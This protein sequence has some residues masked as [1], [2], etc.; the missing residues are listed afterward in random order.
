M[1]A[2]FVLKE[3]VRGVKRRRG[4]KRRCEASAGPSVGSHRICIY[5]PQL[6]PSYLSSC[7]PDIQM[8]V[9]GG[10]LQ[11][12]AVQSAQRQRRRMLMRRRRVMMPQPAAFPTLFSSTTRAWNTN[13]DR[14]VPLLLG[15]V[16]RL[17]LPAV[18]RQGR[19][20]PRVARRREARRRRRDRGRRLGLRPLEVPAQQLF[21]LD[22]LLALLVRLQR[23][24]RRT[25]PAGRVTEVVEEVVLLI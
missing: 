15:L 19:L 23:S 16:V 9:G 7:A 1:T 12:V 17:L 3:K 4:E 24:R 21:G 13:C 22:V 25:Q 10:P 14:Y 18:S 11:V 5:L 20:R 6:L 2:L 8:L